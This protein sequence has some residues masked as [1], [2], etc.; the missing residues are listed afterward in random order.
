MSIAVLRWWCD[1][2]EI[3][4]Q[5]TS[6]QDMRPIFMRPSLNCKDG[7]L[8]SNVRLASATNFRT[9]V[10]PPGA[11]RDDPS[12]RSKYLHSDPCCLSAV[13]H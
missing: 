4:I 10:P 12:N 7:D 9:T 2:D 13:S 5:G 3:Q 11:V 1:L 8:K 6:R